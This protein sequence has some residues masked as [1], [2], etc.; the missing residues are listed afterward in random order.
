MEP[1]ESIM[2]YSQPNMKNHLFAANIIQVQ[3]N[4]A[5]NYRVTTEQNLLTGDNL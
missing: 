3:Y 4:R 1:K 5:Q 2:E